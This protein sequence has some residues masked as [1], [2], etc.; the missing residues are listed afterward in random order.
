[1]LLI[2]FLDSMIIWELFMYL[3]FV[4]EYVYYIRMDDLGVRFFER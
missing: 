1:M 3:E 4:I 2:G